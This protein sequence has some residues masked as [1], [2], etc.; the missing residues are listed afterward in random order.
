MKNSRQYRRFK[1]LLEYDG[2]RYSGWQ[3]QTDAK[4]IQGT[5]LAAGARICGTEVDIQGNGRTDA[6]VHALCYTAHLEAC[7]TLQPKEIVV[8]FNE[9]LPADIVV[10]EVKNCSA[11]F[12]ARHNCLGRSYL[13]RISR[14][15]RAFEKNHAWWVQGPLDIETM[16]EASSLFIGMHDFASFAQ[17]QELKKSTK[18]LINAVNIFEDDDMIY[19]R[20][21]GSHF[22]W[23]MIRRLAGVL[24]EVGRHNLSVDDVRNFLLS[25]TDAPARFTAIPSGLFFERAFYDQED[26]DTFLTE[27]SKT[28]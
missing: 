17:K 1:L 25:K 14:R 19:F 22:L 20:T 23:K 5:L 9:I 6:G 16:T 3:R 4:T 26:F 7:T 13:Y 2:S 11:R 21:V 8:K 24:V 18:V 12:H 27:V 10:L 28:P 15:K